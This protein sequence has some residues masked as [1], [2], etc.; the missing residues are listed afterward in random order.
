MTII[1][2]SPEVPHNFNGLYKHIN[3]YY[4]PNDLTKCIIHI[5]NIGLYCIACSQ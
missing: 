3:L 1:L 2:L 5:P 4:T